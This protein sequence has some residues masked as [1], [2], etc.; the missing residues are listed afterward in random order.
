MLISRQLL[1]LW[2]ALQ[3]S[4]LALLHQAF[5]W[6]MLVLYAALLV[7]RTQQLLRASKALTLKQVN[8]LAVVM[9]L[10]LLSVMKQSGVLHFMLQILLLAAIL[11]WLALVHSNEARQLVWVQYFL[12]GC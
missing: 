9:L 12:L 2:G 8:V 11:R 10:A 1:L 7:F 4:L 3:F 6:W 5:S